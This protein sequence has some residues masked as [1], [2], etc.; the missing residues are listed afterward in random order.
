[1]KYGS[2]EIT[3]IL[4]TLNISKITTSNYICNVIYNFDLTF[5]LL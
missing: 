1:M 2:I 4:I 3:N 5:T